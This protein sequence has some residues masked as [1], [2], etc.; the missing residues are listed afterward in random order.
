MPFRIFQVILQPLQR[1]SNHIAMMQLRIE[2]IRRQ[3][4]PQ[5]VQQFQI[6]R[7]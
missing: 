1:H 4:Q 5:A 2:L 7:P 3:L 6:L